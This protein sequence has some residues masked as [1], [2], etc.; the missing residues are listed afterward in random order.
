MIGARLREARE[1]LKMT[2]E[3]LANELEVAVGTLANWETGQS[4]PTLEKFCQVVDALDAD[5]AWVLGF[6]GRAP[7]TPPPVPSEQLPLRFGDW[8]T[9]SEAAHL[10]GLGDRY[11]RQLVKKGHLVPERAGPVMARAHGMERGRIM[12]YAASVLLFERGVRGA[13]TLCR[14]NPEKLKELL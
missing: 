2:R 4:S 7:D 3:E 5:P 6:P 8:L 1:A 10:L 12:I 13:A 14:G 9:V 11:V